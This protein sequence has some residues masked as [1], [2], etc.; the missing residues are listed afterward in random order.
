MKQR[1]SSLDVKVIAEELAVLLNGLRLSNAYDLSTRVFLFKF[2]IPDKRQ[3]IIVDT[4]FR[5]HT[6]RYT[7]ETATAPSAFIARLRKFLKTRR[8]T[9]VVQVGTDRILQITFSDGMY[10]LFLEFYAAGNIILTDKEGNILAAQ[11]IVRDGAEQEHVLVGSKYDTSMRQN[12][13]GLPKI[14]VERVQTALS[15]AAVATAGQSEL[16]KKKRGGKD[17]NPVEKALR[18]TFP[19]FSP[20]LIRHALLRNGLDLGSEHESSNPDSIAEALGAAAALMRP[21]PGVTHHGY[22]IAKASRRLL[23]EHAHDSSDRPLDLALVKLEDLEFDDYQPFRPAQFENDDRLRIIEYESFNQTVDEFHSSMEGQKLENRLKDRENA[24]KRKIDSAK[25]EQAK[26]LDALQQTQEDNIIRAVALEMNAHRVQEAISAVN[27]LIGQGMDWMD[28]AKLIEREAPRGNEVAKMIKLP[29]KLYENTITVLLDDPDAA[30]ID[31]GNPETDI[32]DSEPSDC[33]DEGMSSKAALISHT[34]TSAGRLQI[35]VNLA[36]TPFA[37]ARL[38]YEDRRAALTKEQKTLQ[39]TTKALKS[40]ERKVAADLRK[41]LK[42][43][44]QVLRPVRQSHWFE[45]FWWFISSEG[46]LVLSGRDEQQAE[47]L[48]RRHL[49]KGDVF[50]GS[51]VEG[52]AMVIVKN[53]IK[54]LGQELVPIPPATLSQAGA[55]S[56]ATSSA[57]EGKGLVSSWW[58]N[59]TQVSKISENQDFLPPGKYEIRGERKLLGSSAPQMGFGI[60]WRT[61]EEKASRR[62]D[63]HDAFPIA[64][65]EEQSASRENNELPVRAA[66]SPTGITQEVGGTASSDPGPSNS[67]D[68][69]VTE[70]GSVKASRATDQYPDQGFDSEEGEDATEDVEIGTELHDPSQAS[71]SVQ[72]STGL[73]NPLLVR[74]LGSTSDRGHAD[75]SDQDSPSRKGLATHATESTVSPTAKPGTSSMKPRPSSP[76][77]KHP[78]STPIQPNLHVAPPAR[79]KTAAQRRKAAKYHDQDEEDR[80]AAMQVLGSAEGQT[81]EKEAASLKQQRKEKDDADRVRRKAQQQKITEEGLVAEE[82]RRQFFDRDGAL[83]EEAEDDEGELPGDYLNL[84][85]G[86]VGRVEAGA[87]IVEAVAFCGPWSAVGRCRFKAKIQPG[88]QKKGKAVREILGR[89]ST[90]KTYP[91]P[92]QQQQQEIAPTEL[93]R[94]QQEQ[95]DGGGRTER[96]PIVEDRGESARESDEHTHDVTKEDSGKDYSMDERYCSKAEKEYLSNLREAEVVGSICV[97]GRIRVLMG[98]KTGDKE[99]IAGK[100]N[101]QKSKQGQKPPKKGGKHNKATGAKD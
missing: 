97:G 2:A 52:A 34:S 25:N 82:R 4:G 79:R 41:G 42:K 51:D 92:L 22:I 62:E 10:R 19:E 43:E 63:S 72:P 48:Y 87:E 69:E 38:Y 90:L 80:S 60:L 54:S 49:K 9:G 8:V 15:A 6:T 61:R 7:R 67:Q 24:A 71:D 20:V 65:S 101:G 55:M 84:I 12:V 76:P 86:L 70:S 50:I 81:R 39:S 36:L 35:D 66:G 28:I 14:T 46:Y 64:S 56:V 32:T 44:K 78:S 53:K 93:V 40:T 57:W 18:N 27:G 31:E 17:L 13:D 100:S 59:A 74:S 30:N 83:D 98:G 21:A 33:E 94:S 29:L 3:Q 16:A 1:F 47:M 75:D 26:R 37:N 11:R 73:T 91:E 96:D 95:M 68:D 58:V 88:V 23:D 45:K 77:I 89:W 5:V 99:L 85:E